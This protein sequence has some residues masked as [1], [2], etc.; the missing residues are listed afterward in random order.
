MIIEKYFIRSK[1][2]IINIE[3]TQVK[4]LKKKDI[5]KTAIRAYNGKSIGIGSAIGNCDEAKLTAEARKALKKNIPYAFPPSSNRT[6]S[7]VHLPQ[8]IKED[9]FV[10]EAQ[11]IV[12]ELRKSRPDF[13]FS[14]EMCMIESEARISNNAGLDLSYKNRYF[15]LGLLIK[16]KKSSNIMDAFVDFH[17]KTYDKKET[18]KEIDRVCSAF[19]KK[20]KLEKKGRQPVVF[21]S[22]DGLIYSKLISELD[23]MKIGTKSSLFTG[24]IGKKA[25][26]ENFSFIQ[27]CD[28]YTDFTC[29]FDAEGSVNNGYQCPLIENGV[30]LRP[31]TDKKT[32]A[33]YKFQQTASAVGEF[34]AVPRSGFPGGRLKN[35][36]KSIKELLGGKKA[37]LVYIASG[38]DFTPDGDFSSPVQLAFYFDGKDFLGRLPQIQ[39][40]SNIYDM[41]GKSFL[42]ASED[43]LSPISPCSFVAMEMDVSEI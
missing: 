11:D 42:G 8:I 18:L 40:K 10:N 21:L 34:D 23:G 30:I 6:E 31:Y 9:D 7:F 14:H 25:F 37:V 2:S 24:L 35:T 22:E 43:K 13:I 33:E 20:M 38:G 28:P 17:G 3:N 4:S 26:G 19:N 16:E 32:A 41:F 36:V 29:F 27:S 15:E 1:H 39:V 5:S 12:S